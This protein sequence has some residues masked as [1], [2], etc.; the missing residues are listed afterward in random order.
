MSKKGYHHGDLRRALVRAAV[1]II[2]EDNVQALTLRSVAKRVGVSH[3]APYRHF[4][5]KAALLASV[6]EEGFELLGQSLQ[7]AIDHSGTSSLARLQDS[8]VA[9][10]H[11]ACNNPSHYRVMFG[12]SVANKAQYTSLLETAMAAFGI[13]MSCIESCQKDGLIA[14]GDPQPLALAAWSLTHGLAMLL[15]DQ[16]IPPTGRP[17]E[18]LIETV[19][20]LLQQ[21][22]LQRS[23]PL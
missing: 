6:A 12:S 1:E 2:Q 13:L 23:S 15:L 16:Q 9:Y 3:T 19:V 7:Q 5:D 17:P 21:G 4:N 18:E 22:L 14:Q 10:V 8:G 11:F 20:R